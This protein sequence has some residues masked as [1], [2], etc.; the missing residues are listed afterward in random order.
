MIQKF[1]DFKDLKFKVEEKVTITPEDIEILKEL[2]GEE[3]NDE[4]LEELSSELQS[5]IGA[6]IGVGGALSMWIAS[7]V[8]KY[9]DAKIK[10]PEASEKEL[11]KVAFGMVGKDLGN[12][13]K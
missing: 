7:V 8:K 6:S 4:L 1:Q 9:K 5:I 12:A 10:N 3:Y 11:M 13:H 2:Q